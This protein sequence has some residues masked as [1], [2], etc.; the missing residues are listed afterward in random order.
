M[1]SMS[2]SNLPGSIDS[3]LQ[4]AKTAVLQN[5]HALARRLL[6]QA[7]RQ[8]PQDYRGWLW[9]A[10]VAT[11]PQASLEYVNRADMLAPNNASVQKARR[12][13]EKRLAAAESS[14]EVITVPAPHAK[15]RWAPALRWLVILL[16]VLMLGAGTVYAW[17]YFQLGGEVQETAVLPTNLTTGSEADTEKP[18]VAAAAPIEATATQTPQPHVPAKLIASTGSDQPRP[19]WTVTPTPSP[20]PTPT[21]TVIPTFVNPNYQDAIRPFGVTANERWVDVNLTTQTLR[22]Y[23]GDT[24]VYTTLISSGTWDHPTVTGQFRIWLT[25]ESQT[26]DGSLLG[27][28]YYLENVPYVMY[29]YQDYALHGTFWHSNFGTPMSHG[30]VNLETSDAAW[31][32]SFVSIGTLVNVHY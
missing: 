6:Q 4:Q 13:A 3:L 15:R 1:S 10:S 20:T 22:A 9:L 12:W 32:Y 23:E 19:T 30:C 31:I 8:D 27:Y 14:A 5:N 25:Y 7:V 17:Q 29:F 21:P 26:M 24:A 16:A 28:D 11:T 18:V 2:A